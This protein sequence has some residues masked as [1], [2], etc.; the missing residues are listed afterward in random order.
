MPIIPPAF[1]A[2]LRRRFGGG[3]GSSEGLLGVEIRQD[4]LVCAHVRTPGDGPPVVEYCAFRKPEGGEPSEIL[5]EMAREAGA[6]KLPVTAVLGLGRYTIFPADTV[7][8][9]RA[10]MAAAIRWRIKD[11]LEFPVEE[12]VVEVFDKPGGRPGE[13]AQQIYVAVAREM[14]VRSCVNVILGAGLNLVSIDAADLAMANLSI[15]SPDDAEGVALLYLERYQG[16][17]QVTRKG[18][19]YLARAMER[20][21]ENMVRG[22]QGKADAG[23]DVLGRLSELDQIGLEIQ[24]TLDYYESHFFQSP[25]SSIHLAPTERAIPHLRRAVADKMGMRVKDLPLRE[26]LTFHAAVDDELLSR[27]MPAIGATLR[28]GEAKG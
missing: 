3:G 1:L 28:G 9:P 12:A 11:R 17:V 27:A 15:L 22:L 6:S 25:V 8:A 14:E 21:W 13:A 19:V 16:L 26:V 23:P 4:G 20:G 24:R 18:T 10:E 7:E 2:P 5:A